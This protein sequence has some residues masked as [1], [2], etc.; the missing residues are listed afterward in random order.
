[1]N[2]TSF[3]D[4]PPSHFCNSAPCCDAPCRDVD[5][6]AEMEDL[7]ND[8][9][10]V[11]NLWLYFSYPSRRET[12]PPEEAAKYEAKL[13]RCR[14]LLE[15]REDIM[16]EIRAARQETFFGREGK[17][18]PIDEADNEALLE[19]IRNRLKEDGVGKKNTREAKGEP[20]ISYGQ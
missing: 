14:R 20:K 12:T 4:C 11:V 3:H 17:E 13:D 10:F 19:I 5:W 1:M 2:N 9:I 6:L 15:K 8:P 7:R 18:E 16:A